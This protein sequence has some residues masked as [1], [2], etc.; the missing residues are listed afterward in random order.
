VVV[1]EKLRT[2]SP[3]NSGNPLGR[4]RVAV[5]FSVERT[6]S[7]VALMTMGMVMPEVVVDPIRLSDAVPAGAADGVPPEPVKLMGPAGTAC[8]PRQSTC[9]PDPRVT[10]ALTGS[11][12]GALVESTTDRLA[13]ELGEGLEI[14]P[15]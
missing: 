1:A 6:G 5:P 9:R 3:Q 4:S 14:A 15:E 2:G 8:R 7:T 10:D 12:L 11:R 13:L